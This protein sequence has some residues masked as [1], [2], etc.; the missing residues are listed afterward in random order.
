MASESKEIAPGVYRLSLL[1]TNAYFVRS[2]P[3][4]ALI[5]AGWANSAQ[6]IREA[7]ALFGPNARPAAILLTHNH[8]DHAGAALDLART[9]QL[10]VY[11]GP[12]ETVQKGEDVAAFQ[13]RIAI[14]LDHWLIFP[15]MRVMPR[16]VVAA[17]HAQERAFAEVAR[18]LDPGSG[19]PG[20]ADWQ[21]IPT[22]G[23]S[24]GHA[25]FFR[26]SDGILITGDAL[27]TVNVNSLWDLLR[28]KQRISGPPRISTWS[29]RAAKRSVAA[30]ARLEPR[31]LA[32]GHGAPLAGPTVTQDLRAFAVRF[33]PPPIAPR[34][35]G[36]SLWDRISMF[37]EHQLDTRLE[38][39]GVFLFRLTRGRIAEMVKAPGD[40][41]ALTTRGRKS[42][43]PRTVV[44][45]GFRDGSD[46]VVVAAN[47]GEPRHPGWYYNLKANPHARMELNGVTLDV[48]AEEL[49]PEEA[50]AFWP[51][52]LQTAPKYARYPKRTTRVIP[53]MRLISAA[54][55]ETP[56]APSASAPQQ[57]EKAGV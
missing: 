34:P 49:S 29:W 37:V 26:P 20:L 12:Y 45:L 56:P 1:G 17:T 48:R 23:H 21:T 24:P 22:P 6:A 5:D 27:L 44:L 11:V 52:I 57:A 51:R 7:A 3:S 47:T 36:L 35:E 18:T 55:A 25:S 8:P 31:V 54:R 50:A 41:L 2:G 4:W 28:G 46:M 53:L 15:L 43:K 14:P 13:R 32:P 19:V 9:W 39:L 42:G 38:P 10:P 40:V 33:S 16:R 30:L